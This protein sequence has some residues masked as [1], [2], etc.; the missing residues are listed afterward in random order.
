MPRQIG[1]VRARLEYAPISGIVRMLAAVPLARA[2]KL[3]AAMGSVVARVDILNRP[4]ALKNLEIAFPD[5]DQRTRLDI[6]AGMYRNWGRMMAEWCHL[7]ELTPDNIRGYVTYDGQE[8]L[9]EAVKL[10]QAH[11]GFLV[12]TAHFGNIELL[13]F[14]HAL[15]GYRIAIVQ[16]PAR[17]PLIDKQIARIRTK[18]G[19]AILH[20]KTAGPVILKYL[21][22]KWQVAIALDLDVRKGVFV[23][24]FGLEASTSDGMARIAMAT[25]APV[26]PA[27]MVREGTGVRQKITVL[28]MVEMV[29][30][31]DREESVREN[32]Q[33]MTKVI[34]QMV[35]R[36]PDH[37]NWIHRRWKTRPPGEKRFY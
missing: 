37:W 21:R 13:P 6:L 31:R 27:F 19:N 20:R 8:I 2:V 24:F 9:D 3:G 25:G 7:D 1:P 26:V 34:E 15:Y 30:T 28:P 12:L 18:W 17:N 22:A 33:R 16:R 10:G 14:A 29:K 11:R 4:I 35:R 36:Y 23:D 32:T 5:L